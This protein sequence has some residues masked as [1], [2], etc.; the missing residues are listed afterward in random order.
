MDGL[1]LN[2]SC[3]IKRTI[4]VRE[5]KSRNLKGKGQKFFSSV[6]PIFMVG[7]LKLFSSLSLSLVQILGAV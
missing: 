6:W 5:I 1:N 7:S 4:F 3:R 2:L